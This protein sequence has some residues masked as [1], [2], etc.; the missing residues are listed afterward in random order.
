MC[1]TNLLGT[2][3]SNDANNQDELS[4][5]AIKTWTLKL[6]IKYHLQL[7][8]NEMFTI[9]LHVLM[10]GIKDLNKWRD[11]LCSLLDSISISI[12]SKLI[13]R[14]IATLIRI[15]GRFFCRNRQDYFVER[16]SN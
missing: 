15:L 9:K 4:Q 7:F 12:L 1:F 11:A 6:K 14:F 16:Q 5:L 13:W 10:K 3:P 2:S 8:K